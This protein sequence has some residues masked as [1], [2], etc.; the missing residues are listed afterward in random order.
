MTA[1]SRL[2]LI[3]PS[4]MTLLVVG[5]CGTSTP[6]NYYTLATRA[7]S[8]TV[9]AAAATPA[10]VAVGPVLL[11]DY[12]DRSQIVFRET[13]YRLRLEGN[14]LWAAPLADMVPRIL[15][16]NLSLRLPESR[17]VGFPQV[18]GPSFDH[19]LA[20]DIGRFDVDAD[21]TATIAARWQ[22]YAAGSPRALVVSESV[23]ERRSGEPGVAAAVAALS[24]S[25]AD[26][27][28]RMAE[29]LRTVPPAEGKPVS[30]AR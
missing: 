12:V 22:V 4:I 11:P 18:T 27:S 1:L 6:T 20:I 2:S 10:V 21:G 24:A 28:D 16:D 13:D 15:V 26:L 17:V 25:L 9:D 14:D 23:S 19:R 7:P 3:V 8:A 30:L 29:A 5:A